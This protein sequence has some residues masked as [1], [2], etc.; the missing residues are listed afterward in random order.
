MMLR[1]Q[2]IRLFG[3]GQELH[4]Y[5]EQKRQAEEE[6]KRWESAVDASLA[7][8]E[9]ELEERR[10]QLATAT[11]QARQQLLELDLREARILRGLPAQDI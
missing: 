7:K 5:K 6:C 11:A 8:A 2:R 9:T 1:F 3:I 10:Q 4:Y